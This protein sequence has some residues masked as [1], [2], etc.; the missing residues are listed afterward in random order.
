[1]EGAAIGSAP[2]GIRVTTSSR[3][4][5]RRSVR[6][7]KTIL[8]GYRHST[9]QRLKWVIGSTTKGAVHFA[10]G[11]GAGEGRGALLCADAGVASRAARADDSAA[12]KGCSTRGPAGPVVAVGGG[13]G[14]E[15][16][17]GKPAAPCVGF[18]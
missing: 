11:F 3:R 8:S 18:E 2:R 12:D 1:M 16:T 5:L 4:P 17:R 7:V 14:T 9:F 15:D 10:T 13:E 6:T